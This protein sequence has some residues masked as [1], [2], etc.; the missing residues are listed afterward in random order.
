M[1]KSFKFQFSFFI[2][3]TRVCIDICKLFGNIE[4]YLDQVSTKLLAIIFVKTALLKDS[5]SHS[6]TYFSQ[7]LLP[8]STLCSDYGNHTLYKT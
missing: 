4:H 3:K 2:C 8:Y 1:K 6:F 5:H 7:L